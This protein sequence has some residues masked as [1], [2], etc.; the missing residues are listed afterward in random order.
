MWERERDEAK[1]REEGVKVARDRVYFQSRENSDRAARERRS[2]FARRRLNDKRR[3][4]EEDE[5]GKKLSAASFAI[6]GTT[7]RYEFVG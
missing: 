3:G 5:I 2:L 7:G 1:N 6:E 4:G